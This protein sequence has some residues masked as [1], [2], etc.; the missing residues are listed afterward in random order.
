M[1]YKFLLFF[2]S[3]LFISGCNTSDSKQKP[4]DYLFELTEERK[5]IVLD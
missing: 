1:A 2:L 3:A 4:C 5:A